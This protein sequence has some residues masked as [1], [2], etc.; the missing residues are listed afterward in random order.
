MLAAHA[1]TQSDLVFVL[2]IL[3]VLVLLFVLIGKIHR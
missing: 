2:L 3:A 1:I